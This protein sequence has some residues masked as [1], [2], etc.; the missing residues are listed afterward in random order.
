MKVRMIAPG[1]ELYSGSAE[2][3]RLPL[4]DGS[5]GIREHHEPE[6][7]LLS[8]GNV[9]LKTDGEEIRFPVS[10]GICEVGRN[11]VLVL[12]EPART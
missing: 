8:E 12:A 9:I 5:C 1:G 2:S 3:V 11:E 6:L 4:P 7:C 10:G